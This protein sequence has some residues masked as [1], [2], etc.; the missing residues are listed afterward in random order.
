VAGD[1]S[2][3]ITWGDGVTSA[4]TIKAAPSGFLVNGS[5]TFASAGQL[6]VVVHVSDV[7]GAETAI[8]ALAVVSAAPPPPRTTVTLSPGSP[9]GAHGWYRGPVGASLTATTPIGTVVA[10]R[11]QLD[12]AP[13]GSFDALAPQCPFSQGGAQITADGQHVLYAASINDAGQKERPTAT[14]VLIDSTP[15]IVRCSSVRP[16]L[17]TGTIGALVKATVTDGTSG[18]ESQTVAVPATTSTPGT[19]IARLTGSDNAGNSTTIRCPYVVLGQINPG[20][21][22]AFKPAGPITQVVSLVAGHIP[23]QATIRILCR[24]GGCRSASQTIRPK[25]KPVCRHRGC[26]RHR[27]RDETSV[28]LTTLFDGWNLRVGTVLEVA[29]GERDT[30][31]RGFVF[32]IRDGR[33]P[34]EV[35]GCLAPGSL[36]PNRGC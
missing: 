23:R 34:S 25:N 4:A 2:A 33:R 19:K 27:A 12:G 20:L 28:D 32:T 22:W 21:I 6:P 35:V 8:Q 31:G 18:A 17:K 11:C 16:I 13:P 3:T 10:T 5:H 9:T 1:F 26:R 7:Q 30:I 14:S 36:V 15:P 24:G 29:I